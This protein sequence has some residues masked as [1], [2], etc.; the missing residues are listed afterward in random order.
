MIKSHEEMIENMKGPDELGP[1]A[2][3]KSIKGR[4]AFGRYSEVLRERVVNGSLSADDQ[5]KALHDENE[6]E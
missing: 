3:E 1:D 4:R 5:Y 6:F 2:N